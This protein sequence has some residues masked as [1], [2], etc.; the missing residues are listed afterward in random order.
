MKNPI[1]IDKDNV[2]VAGHTRLKALQKLGIETAPCIIADDLTE[3]QIKAF[4]IAD[5]STAQIADWD[6]DKLMKELENIDYDMSQFGLEEQLA[7]I[8]ANIEKDI[9]TEE[10][11]ENNMEVEKTPL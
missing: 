5:N 2:I 4:R 1:I 9:I 7:E 3:E 11:K 10:D 6:M 8:Q